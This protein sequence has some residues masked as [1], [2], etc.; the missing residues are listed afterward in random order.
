MNYLLNTFD[1]WYHEHSF[2]ILATNNFVAVFFM[3]CFVIVIS[4][5]L[6]KYKDTIN[7]D[8][9]WMGIGAIVEQTGWIIHRSF[10]GV[11]NAFKV[12]EDIETVKYLYTIE[13]IPVFAGFLILIGLGLILAPALTFI[14]SGMGKMTSYLASFAIVF[15]VWWFAF[16]TV[17]Q[18][19]ELFSFNWQSPSMI[20]EPVDS[21]L[22]I[23]RKNRLQTQTK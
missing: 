7:R 19:H 2:H 3:I 5:F 15:A 13:G 11:I 23:E 1:R 21:T 9:F 22:S 14:K 8:L 12:A 17:D 6:F 16:L 20:L 18:K 10:Y 4:L